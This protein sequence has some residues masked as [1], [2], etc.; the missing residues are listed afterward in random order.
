MLEIHAELMLVIAELVNLMVN[1]EALIFCVFSSDGNPSNFWAG[2]GFWILKESVK[3]SGG[4]L[5]IPDSYFWWIPD[6]SNILKGF[7]IK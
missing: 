1:K 7:L 2:F 4:F 6:S 5:R 3:K